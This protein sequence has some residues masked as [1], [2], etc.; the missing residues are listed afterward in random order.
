MIEIA[1]IAEV[2]TSLGEALQKVVFDRGIIALI[3]ED[4]DEHVVEILW[5]RSGFGGGVLRKAENRNCQKGECYTSKSTSVPVPE[6]HVFSKSFAVFEFRRR[7]SLK[8]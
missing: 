4:D 5:R 6:R 8:G 7:S 3:F 1:E 2:C